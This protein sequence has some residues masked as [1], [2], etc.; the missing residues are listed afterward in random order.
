MSLQVTPFP[1]LRS[2]LFNAGSRHRASNGV[3]N[4]RLQISSSRKARIPT[5]KSF[6]A[7]S[8]LVPSPRISSQMTGTPA[9][10]VYEPAWAFW[11]PKGSIGLIAPGMSCEEL[12]STKP[13]AS[14]TRRRP[15]H[16]ITATR[17]AIIPDRDDCGHRRNGFHHDGEAAVGMTNSLMRYSIVWATYFHELHRLTTKP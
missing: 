1:T 17:G 5:C 9:R 7:R 14:T 15:R 12:L 4:C 11:R 3:R 2:S 13:S 8:D 10:F 16:D 6:V